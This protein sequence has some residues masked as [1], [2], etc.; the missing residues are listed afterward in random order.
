MAKA[1]DGVTALRGESSSVRALA[2]ADAC[3]HDPCRQGFP[4]Q[5]VLKAP[6][7]LEAAPALVALVKIAGGCSSVQN[8]R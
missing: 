6:L 5:P 8:M 1:L 7:L 3:E 2:A 4:A